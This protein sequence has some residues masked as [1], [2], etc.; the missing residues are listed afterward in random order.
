MTQNNKSKQL[1]LLNIFGLMSA[2]I[3]MTS[4]SVVA[5]G[6]EKPNVRLNVERKSGSCPTNVGLWWS[7]LPLEGGAD[8]IVVADTRPIANY[9]KVSQSTKRLVE[10]EAP[11]LSKYASCVGTASMN[12]YS[13]QFRDGKVYFRVNLVSGDGYREIIHKQLATGRPYVFWKA[14]E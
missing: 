7:L 6:L 13:F 5:Q 12:M 9:A 3:I 11:L 10:Y 8:H 14:A 1:R 2:T 4:T